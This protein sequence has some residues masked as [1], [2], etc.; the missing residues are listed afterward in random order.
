MYLGVVVLVA[1]QALVLGAPWLLAYAA[2]VWVA[3]H[4]FVTLYEEPTLT[5]QYGAEYEAFRR[6]VSRWAPRLR[7]WEGP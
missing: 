2:G 3:F 1:G 7:A 4:F 6:A 5:A